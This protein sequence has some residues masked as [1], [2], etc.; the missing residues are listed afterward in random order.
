[1]YTCLYCLEN[2]DIDRDIVFRAD[3]PL[4]INMME[5][6]RLRDEQDSVGAENNATVFEQL[7]NMENTEKI[8]D[9]ASLI[10]ALDEK[11]F[12]YLKNY[13]TAE[14][15]GDMSKQFPVLFKTTLS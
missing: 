15:I 11:V 7:L 8:N 6:R 14:D 10:K 3:Y 1:M 5:Y 2:I 13:H 4:Q 9:T 12:D